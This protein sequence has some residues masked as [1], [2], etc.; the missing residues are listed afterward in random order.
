MRKCW[1]ITVSLFAKA[2]DLIMIAHPLSDGLQPASRIFGGPPLDDPGKRTTRT[3]HRGL[4][5]LSQLKTNL[6][7]CGKAK[8]QIRP[9]DLAACSIRVLAFRTICICTP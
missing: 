2:S 4:T 3:K 9:L 6:A 5:Q 8:S 7:F 1:A